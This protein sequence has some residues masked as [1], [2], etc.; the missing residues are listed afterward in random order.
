MTLPILSLVLIGLG[1]LAA[2]AGS[3]VLLVAAFRES[4]LWGLIVLFAPLGNLIFT[5]VHWSRAK[6]GFLLTV[7]GVL[8]CVG[9][10]FTLPDARATLL[11][12]SSGKFPSLT[13][14]AAPPPPTAADF[15][16]Q[17]AEK[18]KLVEDL[19]TAFATYGQELPPQFKE[20]EKR[21]TALKTGDEAAIA[22][23]NEDAAAYQ[24]KNKRQREIQQEIAGAQSALDQLLD[25]RSRA[26]MGARPGGSK[27]VLMYTTSHCPACKMAKQYMAQKGIPYQEIDV[28]SSR[29]GMAAFQ[30]LGGRGVPLIMVGD[31]R[32][33][34]FNSQQLE[35]MLL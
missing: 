34:G 35:Q 3:I 33:E 6:L 17:I 29:D 9:A 32:M 10:V 23:F 11:Q 30:K 24:A 13:A 22:K 21:R 15:T 16:T 31:K 28:E 25:A 12:A 26:A 18:R 20:L 4:A 7:A 1:V 27:Q 5:C 8:I 14:Q 19:Q 2:L